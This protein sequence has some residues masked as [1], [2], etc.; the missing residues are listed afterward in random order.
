LS[1][2]DGVLANGNPTEAQVSLSREKKNL[3]KVIIFL[4]INKSLQLT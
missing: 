2:A 1:V 3:K 4:T